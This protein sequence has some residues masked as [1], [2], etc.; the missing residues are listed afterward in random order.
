MMFSGKLFTGIGAMAL[1]TALAITA[2]NKSATSSDSGEKV[3]IYLTDDAA[4]YD[5]VFIDIR[6]VEVKLQEGHKNEEHVG[7]KDD[8]DDDHFDDNDKDADNDHTSKD[9]YG[10]WDTL[11]IRPGVYDILKLRNGVDTLFARGT[12][13]GRV[14]K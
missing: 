14:R 12:V 4:S 10:K 6:Y 3:S 7:D 2:C 13:K 5:N 1:C 11:A 8:D 9:Q